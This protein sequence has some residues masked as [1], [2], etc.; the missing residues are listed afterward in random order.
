MSTPITLYDIPRILRP[1]EDPSAIAWSPNAW[2]TR[3]ALAIKGLP[4]KTEW[5]DWSAIPATMQALGVAPNAGKVK[6]TV[7]TIVDPATQRAI[8]ESFAIATYLDTQY[9]GRPL[10]VA[11]HTR[12][13]QLVFIERVADPLMD[14]VSPVIN[15]EE[16]ALCPDADKA[17]FRETWE[18]RT[19]KTLEELA[20]AGEARATALKDLAL[21]LDDVER[22]IAH[23]GENAVFVF[24]DTPS[25]ADTSLVAIFLW[26]IRLGGEEHE[27]VKLIRTA[28]GGRWARYLDVFSK[29]IVDH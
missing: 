22:Y 10:L 17:Y 13:L 15:G 27:F 29:W 18:G 9:P 20:L 2:K 5:V 23:N 12:A 19:G 16:F 8:T 11:P 7:P 21:R 24:G 1:D 25:H 3:L 28:N 14:A 6:Y 4:F 26:A